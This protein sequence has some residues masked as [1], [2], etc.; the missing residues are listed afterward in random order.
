MHIHFVRHAES[1]ANLTRVLSTRGWKHALT[2]RG[3]A[4]ARA[5]CE[6]LRN[7]G[8]VSIYTSPLLR[9]VE[10]AEILAACLE[11]PVTTDAALR[12]FNVG[13]C[14]DR[15]DDEAWAMLADVERRWDEGDLDARIPAG[16]SC[17]EI[18]LRFASFVDAIVRRHGSTDG[19]LVMVGHGGT[20]SRGLPIVLDN[21]TPEFARLHGLA[22]TSVVEAAWRDGALSCLRWDDQAV[23]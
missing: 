21:V 20:L 8:I 15:A 7:A 4:Q 6:G 1:E 16:E 5:L 3:R 13:I 12:E 11:V 2:D 23:D 10:T 19:G 14:E 17:H 22:N 9:A 18:Q